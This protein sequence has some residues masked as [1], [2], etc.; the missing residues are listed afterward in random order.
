MIKFDLND[1]ALTPAIISYIKSRKDIN[2]YDENGMLKLF[3]APMFDVVNSHN[4]PIYTNN[5]IY[6]IIP[7]ESK[8]DINSISTDKFVFK[9]Y[10]LEDI[11]FVFIENKEIQSALLNADETLKFYVLIDIAN[12][13][14]Q[15]LLD[16]IK[17]LKDIYNDKIVLMA[18]NI[19]NPETYRVYCD[20][21]VDYV[22][23]SIGSGN[24]CLS[25]SNVGIHYPIGSLIS[26][27]NEIKKE[28]EYNDLYVTKVIADGGV[29]SFVDV[30]KLYVLG[31]DYV[32]VGSIFNKSLESS[33][34]TWIES[35]SEFNK[36]VLRNLDKNMYLSYIDNSDSKF[37]INQYSSFAKE[38]LNNHVKIFKEYRGMSTKA[39]QKELDRKELVTSEGIIRT[40]QVEYTLD[41]WIDNFKDYLRSTMSYMNHKN[42]ES[43]IGNSHYT[44]ITQNAYNRFNK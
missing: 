10:G 32:M 36:I 5:K 6:S 11:K 18:G 9:A 38:L 15:Y 29:K 27:I 39:I 21:K 22:R 43:F 3:T 34:L 44:I 4:I 23:A 40:N 25:T 19:A 7:R 16:I 13:H 42:M 8:Y 14:M 17:E 1:I 24:V 33:G 41:K 12:G 30:I 28:K 35:N 2:I 26:E 37:I 31:A 20:Y